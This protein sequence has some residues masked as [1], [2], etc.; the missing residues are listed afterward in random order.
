M[1]VLVVHCPDVGTNFVTAEPI[2]G[3]LTRVTRTKD[4][5]IGT[6][7][8]EEV[9]ENREF[10]IV[11][12]LTTDFH[13]ES[14]VKIQENSRV[15]QVIIEDDDIGEFPFSLSNSTLHNILLQIHP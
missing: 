11:M 12:E 2:D 9:E 8:N 4:I 13:P 15:L 6:K 14:L 3:L 7:S 5:T 10:S 1:Y